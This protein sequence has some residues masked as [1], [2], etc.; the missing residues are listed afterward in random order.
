MSCHSVLNI[1]FFP[2]DKTK[3]K[4]LENRK[5]FRRVILLI[6]SVSTPRFHPEEFKI[7]RVSSE[8]LEQFYI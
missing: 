7:T 3:E 6:D 8:A 1:R 4:Y 2:S 5:F